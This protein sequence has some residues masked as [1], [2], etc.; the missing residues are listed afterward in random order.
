MR[1]ETLLYAIGEVDDAA[2]QD[3]RDPKL[4]R[5]HRWRRW[6]VTAA[7]LCLV[8][9]G[10]WT[11]RRFEYLDFLRTGCAASIGTV[12]DGDYYYH[13]RHR[14]LYRYDPETGER[15]QILST[16]WY[17]SYQVNE[18]GVYYTDGKSLYVLDHAA[19]KRTLLY[20]GGGDCTNL[21]LSLY[22]DDVVVTVY[23][24]KT[25]RSY[26]LLLDGK[27]GGDRQEVT[28]PTD[29][30]YYDTHM[31]SQRYF[32]V[33]ERQL[34]LVPLDG[35]SER[36]D[37]QENG[38]S[39]LPDDVAVDAYPDRLGNALWFLC[40]HQT[41]TDTYYI[42]APAGDRTVTLPVANYYACGDDF[43]LYHNDTTVY[44]ADLRTGET[45]ELT[46]DTDAEW[47]SLTGDGQY[48]YSCVPW[49]EYQACWRLVYEDGRP[50]ALTLIDEDITK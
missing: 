46:A 20:R 16:F 13:V 8:V 37:L 41:S 10:I 36:Y 40:S 27:T 4:K 23:D 22:G 39:L 44:A 29:Y 18:Y 21:H 32:R 34:E 15:Q 42:A 30:G 19:K 48:V 3:A 17:N 33:G 28:P 7:C 47:Y 1:P 49:D 24:R 26:Q 45:W 31:F 12:V 38:V 2:V 43:A 35:E 9:L 11:A 50:V 6:L 14:G 5:P 25:D